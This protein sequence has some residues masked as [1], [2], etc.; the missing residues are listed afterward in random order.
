VRHKKLFYV[1]REGAFREKR[2]VTRLERIKRCNHGEADRKGLKG[3]DKQT[4]AN[5]QGKRVGGFILRWGRKGGQGI[6]GRWGAKGL[7]GVLPFR[8]KSEQKC[9]G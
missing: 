4:H 3:A 1:L 5:D 6:K 8:E 2:E 7:P 9:D